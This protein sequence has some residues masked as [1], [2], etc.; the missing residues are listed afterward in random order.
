MTAD[1]AAVRY[2]STAAAVTGTLDAVFDALPPDVAREVPLLVLA[3]AYSRWA[4]ARFARRCDEVGRQVRPSD[5]TGLETAELVRRFGRARGWLGPCFLV[6]RVDSAHGLR[7]ARAMA[8]RG[9]VVM[10]QVSPLDLD[11]LTDPGCVVTAA[12]VTAADD[13]DPALLDSGLPE[14]SGARP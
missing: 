12:V 3:D 13:W 1:V 4:A 7:L 9:P 5:S 6:A 2:P 10:C 8:A 11:S 14:M